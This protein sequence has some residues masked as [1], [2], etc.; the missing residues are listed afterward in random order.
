MSQQREP[1]ECEYTVGEEIAHA[2]SHGLEILL[3]IGGLVVLVAY[4]ALYGDAW[5]V[6]STSIYGSTLVLL[7]TT[8]T[9]Y[10][11]IPHARAK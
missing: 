1:A 4:S 3:S 9:L 11:G 5:H 6:V 10:H 8:S 7:Y 2:V